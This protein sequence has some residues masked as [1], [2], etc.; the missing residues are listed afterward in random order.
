MVLVFFS[1]PFPSLFGKVLNKGKVLK[2]KLAYIDYVRCLQCCYRNPRY[3]FITRIVLSAILQGKPYLRYTRLELINFH[4]KITIHLHGAILSNVNV[5][6]TTFQKT[7]NYLFKTLTN[8]R[9]CV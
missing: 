3:N 8:R 2:F 4:C 5:N 1:L 6:E 7:I 9:I